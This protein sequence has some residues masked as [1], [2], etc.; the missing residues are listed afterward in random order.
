[1]NVGGPRE[2]RRTSP[3]RG[4]PL[5]WRAAARPASLLAPRGALAGAGARHGGRRRPPRRVEH[6]NASKF[7]VSPS[8]F[9]E[10]PL[11]LLPRCSS[12]LRR[13]PRHLL[14]G[15]ALPYRRDPG[16]PRRQC[17][18]HRPLVPHRDERR[19]AQRQHGQ[20]PGAS[21][22]RTARYAPSPPVPPQPL[23]TCVDAR[24]RRLAISSPRSAS[25]ATPSSRRTR[26]PRSSAWAS[27]TRRCPCPSTS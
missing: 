8:V 10:R 12:N 14:F 18:H 20:A 21:S 1:M 16:P 13:T 27:E 2:R 4:C 22:I 24:G 26:T 7:S 5:S 9:P 3:T 11:S 6:E 17:A 15:H 23:L 19:D 25:V